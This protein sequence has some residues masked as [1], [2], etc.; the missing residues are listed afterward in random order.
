VQKEEDNNSFI[1]YYF[2]HNQEEINTFNDEFNI[3]IKT[4]NYS[5]QQNKKVEIAANLLKKIFNSEEYKQ[6][7]YNF[8]FNGQKKFF[9]NNN[10][11][12]IEIYDHLMLGA[13]ILLPVINRQMD[14]TVKMYYSWRSTVGY[15]YPNSLIIY[16][17]SKFHNRY[18][19][20][21]IASNIAHEWTHKMGYGHSQKWTKERDYTVPYGHNSIIEKLCPLAELDK[22]TNLEY[23]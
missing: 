14:I 9:E 17:N 15:T 2:P 20:C 13:E 22:L 4:L 5:E 12:N 21:Q 23:R 10:K 18:N 3:N 1:P 11:T 19:P 16:T 7:V 6:E 8:T